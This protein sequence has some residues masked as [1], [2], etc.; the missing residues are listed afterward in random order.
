MS[1]AYV[2][3]SLLYA[4]SL[5]LSYGSPVTLMG[6]KSRQT[7]S[8]GAVSAVTNTHTSRPRTKNTCWDQHK[9]K[10]S[11]TESLTDG[12]GHPHTPSHHLHRIKKL[13]LLPV[14]TLDTTAAKLFIEQTLKFRFFTTYCKTHHGWN[15]PMC[16]S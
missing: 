8:N 9:L 16:L 15:K 11:H 14:F 13:Y 2:Q 10:T 12:N 3:P 4:L 6:S 1:L 5:Y 7:H